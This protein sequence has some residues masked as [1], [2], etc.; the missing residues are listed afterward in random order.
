MNDTRKYAIYS[1]KSKFTGK[2]ES[3]ENQVEICKRHIK[4]HY[5]ATDKDIVVFEDEGFS[6]ANTNRP[7]FQEMLSRCKKGEFKAVICYRLDRISR[8]TAD[9]VNTYEELKSCNTNFISVSDNINDDSPMGKAM[10]MISSVFAQLERDIIAERIVDNMRELAKSGR[11][12]GGTTPIGY[13]S[14]EIIG[15][16]STDGKVRKAR[17]LEIIPKEAETVKLIFR[18]FIEFNSQTKLDEFCLNNDIKTRS[19]KNYTRCTLRPILKNPVYLIAD[20]DAWNYFEAQG[21]V[22]YSEKSEFDNVHGIMAYN[23]T[24]QSCKGT[25]KVKD[26]SEWIIA[27]GKHEGLISGSDWVKVQ[28]LLDQNKSKSYRKPKSNDALLSGLLICGRCGE[29]MRPK[30]RGISEKKKTHYFN[31]T[32]ELKTRSRGKQCDQQNITHGEELDKKICDQIKM[33]AADN[34]EFI[35]KLKQERKKLNVNTNECYNILSNMQ[36]NLL[37]TEKKIKSLTDR[38]T[39]A[40]GSN[41]FKYIIEQINEYDREVSELKAKIE[42]YNTLIEN[43][44]ISDVEFD[45]LI[46]TFKTLGESLDT[47]DIEQKRAFLKSFI[48]CIVWDGENAHMILF[49]AEESDADWNEIIRKLC[50]YS[51]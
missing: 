5:Q 23:K 35:K 43:S 42:K 44:K 26:M 22:I 13:K 33:L 10:M 25:H 28:Q 49:G 51:K 47:M 50:V 39:L 17:K 15:S 29:H 34:S 20:E 41:A 21:I 8:N 4:S 2:G 14:A 48:K 24:D 6:G 18:K 40:K 1:R 7:Q 16:I 12:L 38:L 19:G 3:I 31:Y 27:V 45:K 46:T 32:C 11:W 9:F 30:A 36:N 37:E